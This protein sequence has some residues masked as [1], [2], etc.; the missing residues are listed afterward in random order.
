MRNREEF[1][2]LASLK[3]SMEIASTPAITLAA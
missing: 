3:Q 2:K 1:L